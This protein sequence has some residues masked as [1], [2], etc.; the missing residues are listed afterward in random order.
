MGLECLHRLGIVHLDVKPENLLVN[1]GVLKIADFGMC[2][3]V[4]VKL[5][6][7]EEGDSRY[8]ARE[9]LNWNGSIDLSR[10]DVFSLAMTV[11]EMMT[12]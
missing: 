9:V 4:R 1:Q 3:A 12:L 11:Y 2:R 8:L 5:G 6:E 10:A 7:V